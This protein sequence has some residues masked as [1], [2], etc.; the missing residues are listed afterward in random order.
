MAYIRIL[1]FALIPIAICAYAASTRAA[2]PAVSRV[3]GAAAEERHFFE[4]KIRPVLAANCFQCHGPDKQEENLRL[5]SRA[6]ALAGGDRGPAIVPGKPDESL[7]IKAVKHL[8]DLEMPPK[9]QLPREQIADLALWIKSGAAWPDEGAPAAATR[10]SG[11]QVTDKDRAHWAFQPV[12]RPSIPAVKNRTWVANPIDAFIVAKLEANGLEPNPPADKRELIRRLYYDLTGLPP[13]PAEV[14]AFVADTS[15]K[16][17]EALVDRL[18]FSPHYGEKWGRYWL[19]LVRYAESNSYERDDPKPHAWRYRDYVIRS[20]NDDKAYDRFIREQL[21]GDEMPDADDD[22][23]IATGFYRLGIWDDEPSDPEQARFDGLDD[24]V[25]TTGQVFLGLTVDCARC[26]DHKIDPIPQKDYYR[27]LSFLAG[28]NYYRNGGPTDELALS[29][30]TATSQDR[31]LLARELEQKRSHLVE[32]IAALESRFRREYFAADKGHAAGNRS[33]DSAT[34]GGADVAAKNLDVASRIQTDGDRVLGTAEFKRYQYLQGRLEALKSETALAGA[35]LGVTESGP[36]PPDTFVLLRGNSHNH[37]DKVNP[38]FPDVLGGEEPVIP[39]PAPGAKTSSR[40][41]ALAN[42]LAS[43]SNPL[44]PRVIVNRIWQYHFGRGI[45]RSP[46]NF[47]LQGDKPTHPELL[48]WLAAEFMSNGWRMKPLHR[49]IVTSNAYKMS[50]RGNPQ[51]LAVDPTNDLFWRFEMRRLTAEETRDSILAMS[52]TLNLKLFGP[53]VYPEIP[54][55]VLAGQSRPGVG[56]GHSPPE[57]QA[58][59]SIYVHVKRSLLLP[60]LEGFDLPETDRSSPVRFS[61]TQPTQALGML[62]SAFVNEQAGL[63]A[64]RLRREAGD[65]VAAQVRLALNLATARPPTKHEIESGVKLI[66]R[67]QHDGASSD[68]ALRDFCLMVLNLNEFI[69]LD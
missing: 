33:K 14:E 10:R 59:R 28:V 49:L 25:A 27:L 68:A 20:F 8:D 1:P 63:F 67:L 17:Y 39:T 53:S 65:D 11:Y 69:Y 64:S 54:A 36:T 43:E 12:K 26:H 18:L 62:N 16:A 34:Q 51:A 7:L 60:I 57:D 42:W 61:T 15:P 21:A 46:N 6:A 9:K 4:T 45:V 66:V 37:G 50:S 13:T 47:G 58:R 56:W 5:D 41:L 3:Q 22:G 31:E 48:D 52:G 55:E 2:D 24:I 19:D 30:N 35:A 23:L 40:R 32:S 29:G 38:A 44:T